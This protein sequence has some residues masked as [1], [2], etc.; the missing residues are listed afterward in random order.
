MFSVPGGWLAGQGCG[1]RGT[2]S[3]A[4][5]GGTEPKHLKKNKCYTC[6]GH[7]HF[8][9]FYFVRKIN[10]LRWIFP[11]WISSGYVFFSFR[12][13][14]GWFFFQLFF[15]WPI[16]YQVSIRS[17]FFIPPPINPHKK[18]LKKTWDDIFC[19]LSTTA[20]TGWSIN[21]SQFK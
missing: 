11:G 5:T 7:R 17:L 20:P 12:Y 19:Q 21:K 15:S 8:D 1:R 4:G 6:I 13:F 10:I 14:L 9:I 16:R 3:A 18:K 2:P